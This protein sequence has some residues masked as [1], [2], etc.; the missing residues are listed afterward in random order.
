MSK[1]KPKQLPPKDFYKLLDE[2]YSIVTL[3]ETREEVKNFF[4]D[5]LS[6]SEA[7]MLSRR[8]QIAK[9]L[10]AGLSYDDIRRQIGTGY[11]TI[12]SV[13][14][15]IDSGWGGYF[16][17]LENLNKV[18]RRKEAE[19]NQLYNN[20]FSKLKSKYPAHFLISNGLD[21]LRKWNQERQFRKKKKSF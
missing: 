5:L 11:S 14:R 21:E 10:L 12:T 15:W 2:F 20:P 17:A 7:L 6:A 19:A 1:V 16:K 18:I 3:L 9:M 8:I 4:K 13:Q